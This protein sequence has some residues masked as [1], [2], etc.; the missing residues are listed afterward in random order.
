MYA[1]REQGHSGRTAKE[2]GPWSG[3]A[4][5]RVCLVSDGDGHEVEPH[6]YEL[7]ALAMLVSHAESGAGEWLITNYQASGHFVL[8]REGQPVAHCRIVARPIG[9]GRDGDH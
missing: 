2:H 1:S 3:A 6:P 7:I 8:E 4:R 9:P 5:T